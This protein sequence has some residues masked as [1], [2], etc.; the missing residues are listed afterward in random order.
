MVSRDLLQDKSANATQLYP[1]IML[2]SV[3][4]EIL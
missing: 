2:R 4:L 1:P 3:E